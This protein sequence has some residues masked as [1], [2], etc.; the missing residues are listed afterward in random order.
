M[1]GSR[2]GPI[3]FTAR[4]GEIV[5]FAGLEGAGVDELFG[6]L[7]GLE[8]MTSGKLWS[9]GQPLLLGSPQSAMRAGWGLI[10]AS[11]RDQGLLM[12]WSIARNMTLLV[13]G[14]VLGRH[15]LIDQQQVSATTLQYLR[16]LSICV[17]DQSQVVSNLSGGNQQKVVLGKWLATNPTILLLNNPTRGVDV[18]AKWEIYEI[19]QQL[20][21][22]GMTILMTSGEVEEILGLS[23]RILVLSKGKLL[24]EFQGGRVTKAEL[25]HAMSGRVDQ[26]PTAAPTLL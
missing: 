13:L 9:R 12:D 10:P 23:D 24:H 20:A 21:A 6:V 15:G 19:C 26:I 17:E 7:F 11:R 1:G 18:G 16:R 4:A 22:Q 2:L 8:P 5:G 14:K 3:S 25:L